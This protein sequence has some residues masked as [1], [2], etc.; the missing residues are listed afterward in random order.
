MTYG[1][2]LRRREEKDSYPP[3][4]HCGELGTSCAFADLWI[5]FM[6]DGGSSDFR[7]GPEKNR[8]VICPVELRFLRPR[9]FRLGVSVCVVKQLLSIFPSDYESRLPEYLHSTDREGADSAL[10]ANH[11]LPK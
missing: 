6:D 3:G 7:C 2:R 5:R 11:A 4:K 1:A 9:R 10:C 8:A